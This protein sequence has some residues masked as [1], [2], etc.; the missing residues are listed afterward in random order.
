[1][2]NSV[3]GRLLLFS[4]GSQTSDSTGYCSDSA[5]TRGLG[6]DS[7][8][9]SSELRLAMRGRRDGRDGE[10]QES[11]AVGREMA[12]TSCSISPDGRGRCASAVENDT[13]S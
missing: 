13:R 1:M 8:S 2:R 5:I 12:P 9:L 10:Q 11:Q 7:A 4:S 6:D 3:V